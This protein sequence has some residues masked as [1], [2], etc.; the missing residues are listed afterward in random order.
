VTKKDLEYWGRPL[1]T[2]T[3]T[4]EKE[5]IIGIAYADGTYVECQP[6]NVGRVIEIDGKF[7]E[8]VW[9]GGCPDPT[10]GHSKGRLLS[11]SG[12]SYTIDSTVLFGQRIPSE[13]V[14][15]ELKQAPPQGIGWDESRAASG[16]CQEGE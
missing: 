12:P 10:G 7:M 14:P 4:D 8:V 16:D 2:T 11:A 3:I 13:S 1:Y 5:N 6:S 15:K 9:D